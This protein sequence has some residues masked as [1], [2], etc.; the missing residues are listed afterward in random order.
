MYQFPMFLIR[1]RCGRAVSL[2]QDK[3]ILLR[4]QSELV[5]FGQKVK[6][7]QTVVDDVR[8][9]LLYLKGSASSFWLACGLWIPS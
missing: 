7:L 3:F 8:R 4:T 5:A 6:M 9:E 2:N 1:A